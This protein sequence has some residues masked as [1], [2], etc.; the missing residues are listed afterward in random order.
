MFTRK[1]NLDKH[2]KVACGNV[3]CK[4]EHEHQIVNLQFDS[5]EE[6]EAYMTSEELGIQ[7]F[8]QNLLFTIND[9]NFVKLTQSLILL[10]WV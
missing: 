6:G 1:A 7:T 3:H 4:E 9:N 8:I 5:F 10:F 2:L